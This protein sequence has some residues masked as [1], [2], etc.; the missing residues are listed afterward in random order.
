MP[1]TLSLRA[2]AVLKFVI[3]P[4]WVALTAYAAWRLSSGSGGGLL[5]DDPGAPASA[6]RWLLLGLIAASLVV[7]FAFVIPLKRVRLATNGLQVSNYVRET[8]VPF[9]G[10]L[11]VRQDWLP[12]FGLITLK[13]RPGLGLRSRVIFMPA[14]SQRFAFWRQAY[15]R[16]D[17]L[18]QEL[19]QLAGLKA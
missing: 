4:I 13:V 9:D 19:R 18:V 8:T 16:E 3:P 1:R 2:T 12:T 5:D 10:I 11:S 7:L 6:V 15:W 14:G 17:P